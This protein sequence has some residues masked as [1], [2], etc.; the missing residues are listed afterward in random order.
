MAGGARRIVASAV[1]P[2][3]VQLAQVRSGNLGKW[4]EVAATLGTAND[5]PSWG[6]FVSPAWQTRARD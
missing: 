4:R 2:S 6:G 1:N 3:F 5:W